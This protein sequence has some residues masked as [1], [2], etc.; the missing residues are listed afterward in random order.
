MDSLSAADNDAIAGSYLFGNATV[1]DV[2]VGRGPLI[3]TVLSR[4]PGARG[5]LLERAAMTDAASQ[6]LA[7]AGVLDRCD[8]VAGNFFAS[9]PTAG[10]VYLLKK[11]LHDWDDNRAGTILRRCRAAMHPTARLLIAEF[12]LPDDDRPSPAIRLDMLMLV[13]A[14]GRERTQAEYAEL[15][16]SA[17]LC[18]ERI[19]TTGAAIGLLEAKPV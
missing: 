10:D 5:V 15:L 1:I 8:V 18:L 3:A 16:G 11:V 14:G 6:S 7:A 19:I 17:G 2:A 13:Y 9:V 4:N 12:V